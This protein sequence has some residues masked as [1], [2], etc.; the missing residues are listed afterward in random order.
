VSILDRL[1]L[2]PL[3]VT[4]VLYPVAA[5][6]MLLAT[7]RRYRVPTFAALNVVFLLVLIVAQT[8]DGTPLSTRGVILY[9]EVCGLVFLA[10]LTVVLMNYA[11]LRNGA[12]RS[13]GQA[14]LAFLFPLLILCVVKYWPAEMDPLGASLVE[15]GNRHRTQFFVGISYMAFRLSRLLREVQNG[16]VLQPSLAE[17]LAFAFFIPTMTLG[18]IN[19][20]SNMQPWLAGES[21]V[22]RT[23]GR[24]WLRI[25]IGLTKYLLLAT[26]LNQ[27]TYG[28]LLLDGH[29]HMRVDVLFAVPAYTLY[30]YC[31]FSGFCDMVIGVSTLL[32]IEVSENFDRP[33]AARNLQEFWNAWHM[34][35]SFWFRDMMFT[36]MLKVLVRKFGPKSMNHMIAVTIF[37]VFLVLGIWHGTGLNFLI[38]GSLQALGVVTVHYHRLALKKILSKEALAA[39][40][41][42]RGIRLASSALTFAYFSGTLFF[43]ANSIDDMRRIASVIV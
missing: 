13:E 39:Y 7:P 28:G 2:L 42:N 11:I 17:Y 35:L 34:T 36:P 24:A 3:I 1:A 31:N 9:V 40:H 21:S 38:F 14:W 32:G 5:K 43:F 18:P 30:L 41:E 23:A 16:V 26:L 25:L 20:Y 33:F 29:P 15:L 19:S 8:A 12:H 6:I 10:Y 22:S 37:S 27:F 4:F